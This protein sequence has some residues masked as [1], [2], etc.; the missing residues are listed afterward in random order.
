MCG[1]DEYTKV[2]NRLDGLPRGVEHLII[3]LGDTTSLVIVRSSEADYQHRSSDCVP[4]HGVSGVHIS[5]K[6][7]TSCHVIGAG[8]VWVKRVCEQ[9]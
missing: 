6:I 7:Q 8:I 4:S 3:Q 1:A 9:M 5:V 2:F